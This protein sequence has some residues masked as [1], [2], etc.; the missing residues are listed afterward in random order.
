MVEYAKMD[1]SELSMQMFARGVNLQSQFYQVCKYA[2][3][4]KIT[5]DLSTNPVML[6][7]KNC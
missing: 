3:N 7:F 2:E 4:P 6:Y 5:E 1:K